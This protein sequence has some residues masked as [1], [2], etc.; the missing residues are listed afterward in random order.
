MHG[1]TRPDT[2]GSGLAGGGPGGVSRSS[3]GIRPR[4][5]EAHGPTGP[6]G[7][8]MMPGETHSAAPG[9]AADLSRCQGC[10]SLQQVRRL[11]GAEGAE[12]LGGPPERGAGGPAARAEPPRSVPAPVRKLSPPPAI[13]CPPWF[14]LLF[15]Q[16]LFWGWLPLLY[17]GLHSRIHLRRCGGGGGISEFQRVPSFTYPASGFS[18][19]YISVGE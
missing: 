18:G 16:Q 9:A 7:D 12:G 3:T 4:V 10:A 1:W 5:P 19:A 15:L 14:S 8:T 6:G 13:P 2:A 11:P 17:L